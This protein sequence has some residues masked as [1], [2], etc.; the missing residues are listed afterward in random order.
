M[1]TISF[2]ARETTKMRLRLLRLVAAPLAALAVAAVWLLVD[3]AAG[4][5]LHQPAF[6]SGPPRPLSI[7]FAAAVAPVAALAAWG[8]LAVMERFSD[9]GSR[10]WLRAALI[11][12]LV[13]LVGPLAGHGVSFG[14]RAT[15]VAMHLAAAAVVI[16]WLY[17]SVV[18][19]GAQA[20]LAPNGGRKR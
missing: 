20:A 10:L 12:L 9:R 7:G 8:L 4:L 6:G 3:K 2:Q 13:S 1:S 16:P 11:T 19:S 15:L 18:R 5:A 17:R 14:N